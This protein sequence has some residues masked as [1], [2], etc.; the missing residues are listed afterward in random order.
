MYVEYIKYINFDKFDIKLQLFGQLCKLPSKYLAKQ[1]FVNRLIRFVNIDRQKQGFIPDM[2]RIL[3][4]YDLL[5]VFYTFIESGIF[6][7]KSKWKKILQTKVM[8][9]SAKVLYSETMA[10]KAPALS[11]LIHPCRIS[12]LWTI[13]RENPRLK[14]IAEIL[15]KTIGHG[16]CSSYVRRC[17][18]C[19]LLT[20]NM[21]EHL[22]C[23]CHQKETERRALW[24]T[25]IEHLGFQQYRTLIG[26][27]CSNQC[28]TLLNFACEISENSFVNFHITIAVAKLLMPR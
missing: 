3:Q 2:Y 7:S 4:Y 16:M 23:F 5:H 14:D 27:D 19:N 21:T 1:I 15:A 13:I 24:K 11:S 10:T 26:Y 17:S 22:L 25:F 20:I 6:P 8:N 9:E 18:A 28:R 12:P